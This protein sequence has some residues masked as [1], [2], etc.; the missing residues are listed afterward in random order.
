MKVSAKTKEKPTP[1]SV[2]YP[3]LNP[4]AKLAELVKNFGEDVCAAAA[5]GAIVI[6]LQAFMRRLIE[7]GKNAAELQAEV[8]KWKPD[9]RSVVRQSAFEKATSVLDKLSP[10]ERKKLLADLQAKM[11]GK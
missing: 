5:K 10:E 7:K 4:D 9:T 11:A 8:S 2:D 1:L 6:S 3:L